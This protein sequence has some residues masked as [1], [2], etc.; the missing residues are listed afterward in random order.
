MSTM[1]WLNFFAGC[2]CL[3]A[4][5]SSLSSA[6]WYAEH[7]DDKK[8]GCRLAWSSMFAIS[9]SVYNF[10]LALNGVQWYD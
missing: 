1:R 8:T 5:G 9:V 7:C 2:V 6:S 10:Y 3:F 4:S